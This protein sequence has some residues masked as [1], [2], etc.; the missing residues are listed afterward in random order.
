MSDAIVII[1]LQF[2][3][4]GIGLVICAASNKVRFGFW[5]PWSLPKFWRRHDD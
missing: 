1:A 4:I 5:I 2:A 3:G